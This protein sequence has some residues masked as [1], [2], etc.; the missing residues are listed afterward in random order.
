MTTKI[1]VVDGADGLTPEMLRK[2][3]QD[4]MHDGPSVWEKNGAAMDPFADDE[5]LACGVENPETC[6]SCQ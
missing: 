6:E 4:P 2:P 3:H 5:P 1:V